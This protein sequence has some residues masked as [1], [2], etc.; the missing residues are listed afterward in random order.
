MALFRNVGLAAALHGLSLAGTQAQA[1]ERDAFAPEVALE[2]IVHTEDA[3]RFVALFNK[4]EVGPDAEALQREYL[5]P[6]SPAVAIF[7]PGRIESGANLAEAIARNPSAYRDAIE[8]CLPVVKDSSRELRAIYLGLHRLFP[9]RPLP[10]VHVLFGAGNSGGTAGAGAQVLGLEV[11]CS[12]SPDEEALRQVLRIFYAHETVHT[13]QKQ[14]DKE[15]ANPLLGAILQE[16]GADYI[17]SLVLGRDPDPSKA[18]WAAPREAELWR[19]LQAD[20]ALFNDPPQSTPEERAKALQRWVANYQNAPEGWPF[21]VGYWMG[22]RIWQRYVAASSDVQV[23][24][25]QVIEWT[26][27]EAILRVAG[28]PAN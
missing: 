26:D 8:R 3:D 18:N 11:L 4:D 10:Q 12:I 20:I 17:A 6:G 16:G 25:E 19:Q 27:F 7:T 15:L 23:A 9:E 2:A 13:W 1:Q 14:S 22:M 21:E 5:D 28:A 24:T